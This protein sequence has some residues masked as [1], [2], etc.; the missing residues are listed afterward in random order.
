MM[1]YLI[2]GNGVAGTTAAF[3]IRKLDSI[4]EITILSSESLPFYS[5][6]R[7]IDFLADE[8]DVEDLII[9]KSSWYEKNKIKLLLNVSASEIDKDKK[10]VITSNGGKLEY[11]KLLV[12]TGGTSFMPAIPGADKKGV[13]TLRT[14]K[15]ALEI[16]NYAKNAKKVLL[17]GGG[18]LGIEAGNSLRKRGHKVSVAEFFQRL[19]PRQLDPEGAKIFK[20]Q[21]ETMGFVFY[22]GAK[23]KEITGNDKAAGLILEDGTG[24]DSD[25][26][27]IS[28]GIR[29]Q[30]ELG[31]QLGVKIN[32]GLP[33][34][35]RLETEVKDIYAAGDLIEH[36]GVFYGIWPAAEKQG[37]IAGIN[38]A[39][40]NALYEGTTPSNVLKIAGINL[41]AAGDIDTEGKYESIIKKDEHL[42]I[43]KKLVIKD[44]VLSGCILY[45]DISG[46]RKILKAIS[47]KKNIEQIRK[48]LEKWD[49]SRL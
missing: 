2:I 48:D 22:L 44:R 16:I 9:Y 41:A 20:S 33:V 27:I 42:F 47:E 34:N 21:M 29:P 36:R 18:L 10:Q 12:S 37:E 35:D 11:D 14:L 7:L 19:L 8:A 49:L 17:I 6:I 31:K 39:G 25:L 28:A 43:Y 40:G 3:N 30:A 46:Y 38:M 26:I 4:G 5:R 32:K 23:S 13:F 15:D 1:K 24:I 45:G